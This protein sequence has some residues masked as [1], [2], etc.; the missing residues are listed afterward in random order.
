MT[1]PFVCARKMYRLVHIS[2]S[3]FR[4]ELA[5]IRMRNAAENVVRFHRNLARVFLFL[6]AK[7]QWTNGSSVTD[8]RGKAQS[9]SFERSDD[10]PQT[11]YKPHNSLIW[12]EIWH[13]SPVRKA[14]CLRLTQL[15]SSTRLIEWATALRDGT[16]QRRSHN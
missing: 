7:K 5:T 3:E 6:I 4:R 13:C 15:L 8:L 10:E 1:R 12:R 14:P 11:Q 16:A 2:Q 9:V